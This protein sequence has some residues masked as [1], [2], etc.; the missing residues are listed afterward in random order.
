MTD[1]VQHY[2]DQATAAHVARGRSPQEA[3]RAA[4]LELGNTATVS[5][6]V[7]RSGWEN[8][9]DTALTDLRYAARRLR[10]APGFTAITLLT[11]A[12]GVGASTA[13][14]SAVKPI[15]YEPLP[16]P[17]AERIAMLWEIRSDG[18]RNDGTFGMYRELAARNRSFEALAVVR[19]WLPTLTGPDQP[20]RLDGQRVSA[21][22]FTVLR[23]L[24]VLGQPSKRLTTAGCAK[25]RSSAMDCAHTFGGDAAS[26]A[27]PSRR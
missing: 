16:Y 5:E 14:F 1:E 7:R 23:V 22:Y 10:S 24:P 2:L 26:S 20:E 13:I 12:L 17:G 8:A 18:A 9:V 6:Q 11:L 21:S 25:R 27:A 4:L 15:L 3:R 19:S